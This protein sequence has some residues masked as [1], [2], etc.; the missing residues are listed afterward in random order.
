MNA[1]CVVHLPPMRETKNGTLLVINVS[2]EAQRLLEMA[3]QYVQLVPS[4]TENVICQV[5][6]T[7]VAAQKKEQLPVNFAAQGN[8]KIKRAQI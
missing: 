2:A 4:T 7:Q 5:K 3:K 6:A 8:I 1:L